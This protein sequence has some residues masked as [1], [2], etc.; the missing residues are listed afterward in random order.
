MT[1]PA[2]GYDYV[3]IPLT[4]GTKEVTSYAEMIGAPCSGYQLL[5]AALSRACLCGVL[6]AM[7][8]GA[9][10]ALP[11]QGAALSLYQG[12]GVDANLINV[13]PDLLTGDLRFEDTWF[14]GAGYYHPLKTPR[15]LQAA[16]QFLH[17]YD[18]GTGIELVAVK[19]YGMQH[20]GE[21][22]AAYSFR[23]PSLSLWAVTVRFGFG[24]GLS[25]AFGRPEY[26]DGTPEE[27]DKRY[28]LQSYGAYELEWGHRDAPRLGL[29][30][31]IHHRSG[32]YGIIAPPHVGSNF[33]AIGLR[34]HF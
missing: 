34:Y 22:D 4:I 7:M 24:F 20:N 6:C 29:I 10:Q 18:T 19:H 31:R 17:I 9:A 15:F 5:A 26:E 3:I 11:P 32:V 14:T 27:P 1:L 23:F 21:V 16:L 12:Q 2:A 25:Y 33:L 30:T 13:I 28:R 8:A